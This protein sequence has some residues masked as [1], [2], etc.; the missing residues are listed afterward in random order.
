MGISTGDLIPNFI[1]CSRQNP[2]SF[3]PE[4]NHVPTNFGRGPLPDRAAPSSFLLGPSSSP[5]GMPASL[6]LRPRYTTLHSSDLT[7]PCFLSLSVSNPLT[8]A[9]YQTNQSF[10]RCCPRLAQSTSWPPN[11][12]NVEPRVHDSQDHNRPVVHTVNSR[13]P[14]A[15]SLFAALCLPHLDPFYR[16]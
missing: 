1:I 2:H 9:H 14:P 16:S 3:H 4:M 5:A 12:R 10:Q 8:F 11:D 15:L 6:P 13:N 7:P